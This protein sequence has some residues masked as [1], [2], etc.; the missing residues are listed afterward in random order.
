[1]N[2]E[3]LLFFKL[4]MNS[5]I[6]IK[7]EKFSDKRNLKKMNEINTRFYNVGLA[8]GANNLLIL[9]IDE[10]NEGLKE[11]ADYVAQN[12]EPKTVM[13]KS[14]NNGF[15]YV[16]YET[17]DKYTDEENI[18]IKSLRN[19]AG[20]RNKGLDIR[21]GNGYIV[22]EP[23]T[24]NDKKY[25]F[26]R[27]Y[28]D[29]KALNMP[30]SLIKWLLEKE[31]TEIINTSFNNNILIIMKDA[32]DLLC[33]LN[34]L[35]EYVD[36]SKN[37][38]KIT[39]AI[40][41]LLHKYNDFTELQLFDIWDY[42][43][44]KGNKY[45]QENNKVIW[46]N[47]TMETNFNYFVEKCNKTLDKKNKINLFKSIKDYIPILNDITTIK[48]IHMNNHHMYDKDYKDNQLTEEIFNN[49]STIIIKST[50]G[51]GKTLNV[52]LFCK[53]YEL[54]N[55]KKEI[56]EVNKILSIV[57]R[58]TLASQ[59]IESFSEQGINM[60]SYLDNVDIEDNNIVICINSILRYH[61]YEA[62]FFNNLCCLH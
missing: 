57:S 59:H 28:K 18:L 10:K 45:N 8:C 11:W 31:K 32:E 25:E 22:C 52:A 1:M 51:T 39:A 15:H 29:T 27:H 47:I 4:S 44:K 60:S 2:D 20:Y 23:S 36:N 14:P 13:Q 35:I 41:N 40:K 54:F 33:I 34:H 38:I 7:N 56:K 5:K 49:N 43:S 37:W 53:K 58:V 55:D 62:E 12:D 6:P 30:L 61:S 21:K 3:E 50:T 48:T 16:F 19:K 46:N 42:W 17:N 24:I 9:D 26:I